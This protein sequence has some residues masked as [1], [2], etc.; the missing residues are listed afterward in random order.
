MK[1]KI[2]VPV[3]AF[4]VACAALLFSI[5]TFIRTIIRG[6]LVWIGAL[7]V[8]GTALIVGVCAITI[9]LAKSSDYDEDEEED[10]EDNEYESHE[11]SENNEENSEEIIEESTENNEENPVESAEQEE[12]SSDENLLSDLPKVEE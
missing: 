4:V 1:A 10:I 12:P 8:T 9:Y 2:L 7:Q 5:V 6:E 11:V 3:I